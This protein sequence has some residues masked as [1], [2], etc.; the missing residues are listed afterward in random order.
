MIF[1]AVKLA[2]NYQDLLKIYKK[3]SSKLKQIWSK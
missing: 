2:K 1:K 3:I